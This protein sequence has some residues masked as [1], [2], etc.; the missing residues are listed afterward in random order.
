M[1]L[2]FGKPMIDVIVSVDENVLNKY[3]FRANEA[4][5]AT[6]KERGIFAYILELNPRFIPGGSVTNTARIFQWGENINFYFFERD[7]ETVQC[8]VLLSDN[9][10]NRSLI[11]NSLLIN[12]EKNNQKICLDDIKENFGKYNVFYTPT[13]SLVSF[14]E[15]VFQ[16][17]HDFQRNNKKI[18]INLGAPYILEKHRENSK[19]LFETADIVIGNEEEYRVYAKI[20]DISDYNLIDLE[21]L[22][23]QIFSLNSKKASKILVLTRSS[24]PIITFDGNNFQYYDIEKVE[25]LVDS[26]GAG[27][28]FAGGFL[29]KYVE[30]QSVSECIQ[31]GILCAREILQVYGCDIDVS[32]NIV[33]V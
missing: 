10:R 30:N 32:K 26:T 9:G 19:Y 13:Y 14:S 5:K 11:T 7:T 33:I 1:L 4:R 16:I 18:V 28:A 8:A 17:C 29:A 20:S 23:S 22:I 3:G 24:H 15:E 21:N 25:N 2:C 27:D 31:C 6:E 12:S